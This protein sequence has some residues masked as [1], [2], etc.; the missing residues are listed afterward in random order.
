[1]GKHRSRLTSEWNQSQYAAAYVDLCDAAVDLMKKGSVGDA[2]SAI[3]AKL[4]SSEMNG[5]LE[6]AERR[7]PPSQRSPTDVFSR[8]IRGRPLGD[9][10]V[11]DLKRAAAEKIVDAAIN[12]S[13]A[14]RLSKDPRGQTE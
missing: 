9:L 3:M 5:M 7:S 12:F 1:M 2:I 10:Q 8:Q 4:A 11:G 6:F 14:K 13:V